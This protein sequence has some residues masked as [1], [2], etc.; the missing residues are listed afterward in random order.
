MAHQYERMTIWLKPAQVKLLNKRAK[1]R[2]IN[3]SASEQ[4]RNLIDG[5]PWGIKSPNSPKDGNRLLITN[6]HEQ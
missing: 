2:T 6:K 1:D 3:M 4:L 5:L